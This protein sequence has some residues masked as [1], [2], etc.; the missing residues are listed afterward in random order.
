MGL[1][2]GRPMFENKRDYPVGRGKSPVH[3]RFKK[4]QSGNP[5]GPHPKNL[6][7][8]L[9]EA[10]DEPVTATIDGEVAR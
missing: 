1:V 4:G 7:A 2:Y 5:R 10:L 8:L 6:P 9:I 3:T